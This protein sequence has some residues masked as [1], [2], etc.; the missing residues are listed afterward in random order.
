MVESLDV[1]EQVCFPKDVVDLPL[2]V[3]GS[4]LQLHRG[5]VPAV[6]NSV[7]S[8]SR[9][10][11][12]AGVQAKLIE[13]ISEV[14]G[15]QP[16]RRGKAVMHLVDVAASTLG[17][18]RRDLVDAPKVLHHTELAGGR[19]GNEKDGFSNGRK[20]SLDPTL[21]ERLGYPLGEDGELP[22]GNSARP[23]VLE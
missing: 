15:G 10:V 13:P 14:A 11:S 9:Q 16:V 6:L 7:D 1:V 8:E 3:Q 5:H 19:L 22:V 17:D 18:V 23:W 4:V 2:K 20:L 21:G 12:V